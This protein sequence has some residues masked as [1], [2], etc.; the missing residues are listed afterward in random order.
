MEQFLYFIYLYLYKL[1]K[2]K[3]IEIYSSNTYVNLCALRKKLTYYIVGNEP[4]LESE[5]TENESHQH[6]YQ[7]PEPHHCS[8]IP[9]IVLSINL[10]LISIGLQYPLLLHTH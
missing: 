3:I 10:I 5:P 1:S 7:E 6:F 8:Y 4:E 2:I 9:F